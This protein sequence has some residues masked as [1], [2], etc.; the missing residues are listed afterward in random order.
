[1]TAM[2]R[3]KSSLTTVGLNAPQ[4]DQILYFSP[5]EIAHFSLKTELF[6]EFFP[7]NVPNVDIFVAKQ[8]ILK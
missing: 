1:M 5:W 2:H 8:S 7:G 6:P 3:E 4:E